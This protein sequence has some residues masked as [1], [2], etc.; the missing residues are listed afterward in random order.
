MKN[1][2][3]PLVTILVLSYNN[4]SISSEAEK[5]IKKALDSLINQDW[6]Y[7]EILIQDDASTDKTPLIIKGYEEDPRFITFSQ[8]ASNLGVA[9]NI[10]NLIKRSSGKYILWACLDDFYHSSYISECVK[11]LEESNE[12]SIC[13][14]AIRTL[15]PDKEEIDVYAN[16]K[17]PVSKRDNEVLLDIAFQ[18]DGNII[19]CAALNPLIH[20]VAR[21]ELSK[22]TLKYPSFLYLEVSIPLFLIW[23]GDLRAVSDI[24]FENSAMV[25]FSI[26]YP[27]AVFSKSASKLPIVLFHSIQLLFLFIW[28]KLTGVLKADMR[29]IMAGWKQLFLFYFYRPLINKMKSRI[30]CNLI[31]KSPILLNF[32]KLFKDFKNEK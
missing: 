27:D 16:I 10:K 28:F 4:L 11:N 13:Q 3:N 8:N 18:R 21:A 22:I 29:L 31:E 7:I 12:V 26:R 14:S 15:Y 2:S 5:E 25:P 19:A 20:G 23:A 6:P 32:Y 24:L 17:V 1:K 30:Y 9:K